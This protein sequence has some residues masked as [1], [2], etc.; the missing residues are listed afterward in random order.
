MVEARSSHGQDKVVQASSALEDLKSAF[1]ECLANIETSGS[2]CV[3]GSVENASNPG[4]YI[5]KTDLGTIGLPLS[6]RDA[7]AI[8]S[9][10]HQAPF[11]KGEQT[12]V[13]TSVRKTWELSKEDFEM[14]NPAWNTYV[15]SILNK[16]GTG[17]GFHA[18]SDSI[19]AQLYKLLLYEPGAM[20]KAH[21]D[22]E[23]EQGM[24]GTLIIALPSKHEGGQVHLSHA[25][26]TE[27][28]T[29]ATNS[30]YG[31]T[32]LAWFSDVVHEVKPVTSGHRLVLTYN[33]VH[34]SLGSQVL[35]AGSNTSVVELD[36]S[37]QAWKTL[38]RTKSPKYLSYLLEH[39]YTEANFSLQSTK[40]HDNQVLTLLHG[41]CQ[42]YDCILYLAS[43]QRTVTGGCAD[44]GSN[45]EGFHDIDD[46][47]TTTTL[48]RVVDV[49][50]KEIGKQIDLNEKYI[51]QHDYFEDLEPDDEEYEGWM[52]NEGQSATQ[53]YQR[54]VRQGSSSQAIFD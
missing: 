52:G 34:T 9:V 31:Y 21:Q 12:I 7:Q 19:S 18:T 2:F 22:S 47:E 42:K 51:I 39:E 37:F 28:L 25:G 4:L 11:G 48:T 17:L 23:K 33:L 36:N 1:D 49:Y 16:V 3:D 53:T 46:P 24:F 41:L 38:D 8:I 45:S 10:S 29:T 40:G 13:D 54:S 50:G 6:D 26:K 44:D 43:L 5:A 35:S 27:V 32:Y 15:Q 14:K 20:F 30:D